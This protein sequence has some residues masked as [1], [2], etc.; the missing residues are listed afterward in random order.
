METHL[1]NQQ[2]FFGGLVLIIVALLAVAVVVHYRK[3]KKL[4]CISSFSLYFD[5]NDLERGSF[6]GSAFE[7]SEDFYAFSPSPVLA[8]ESHKSG[9]QTDMEII[10]PADLQP[11]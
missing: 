9:P 4:Q 5:P 3:K 8:Y 10:Q 6:S 11:Y 7:E 2:F 1:T